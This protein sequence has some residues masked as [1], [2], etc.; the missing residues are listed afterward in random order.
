MNPNM[1]HGFGPHGIVS[2]A[3][4]LGSVIV[5]VLGLFAIAVMA[6]RTRIHGV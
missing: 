1:S 5:L 6:Y 3:E 4:L 2:G